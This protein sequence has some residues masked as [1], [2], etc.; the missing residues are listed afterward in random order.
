MHKVC[1][2]GLSE[3]V[4]PCRLSF[5]LLAT[6][7]YM[8]D[9]ELTIS[10]F[11]PGAVSRP[12][13]Q[14]AV[15]PYFTNPP[16]VSYENGTAVFSAEKEKAAEG[17]LFVGAFYPGIHLS[18]DVQSLSPGSA[19]LMEIAP[20]DGSF[21]LRVLAQPERTVGFEQLCN[22]KQLDAKV[23]CKGTVPPP[24]FR[25]SAIVAGPTVLVTVRK[26]DTVSF[27][28]SAALADEPDIRKK[29][30]AGF[31]KCTAGASL[32]PGGRAVLK[33]AAVSLTAGVGQAD[34]RIVT[35]GPS[36]R[37]YLENGRMFCTFSARAGLNRI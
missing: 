21:R 35:E 26:N 29:T 11:L 1:V 32:P 12:S 13:L 19:A 6:R 15:M 16:A 25:L 18:A 3:A 24:P 4:D 2:N 37:P 23:E 33:R 10:E 20:Y 27:L 17:T 31:L 34:F 22:G 14:N 9:N 7:R 36:C 30:F 28:A 5:Q 8:L